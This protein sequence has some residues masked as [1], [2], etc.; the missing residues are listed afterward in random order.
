MLVI[1]Q[2]RLG[3]VGLVVEVIGALGVEVVLEVVA[4]H[5]QTVVDDGHGGVLARDA[6]QPDARHVDVVSGL[7]G[8][9]EMPL[10]VENGVADA[11]GLH[12]GRL[13]RQQ[14]GIR[15][16]II[17]LSRAGPR[18]LGYCAF[19][20]GGPQPLLLREAHAVEHVSVVEIPRLAPPPR[21]Q[22]RADDIVLGLVALEDV[23]VGKL[24]EL[25]LV[26]EAQPP[27]NVVG[28]RPLVQMEDVEVGAVVVEVAG[29]SDGGEAEAKEGRDLHG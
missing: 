26:G 20:P 23:V 1:G 27:G 15:R 2:A 7:D 10:L 5:V 8:V 28:A 12:D 18:A 4:V 9:H 13:L 16:R 11:E 19:L 14:L 29:S 22:L 17:V 3:Q 24:A 21:L 6:L 25:A